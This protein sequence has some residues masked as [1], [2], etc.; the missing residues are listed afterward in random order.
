MRL[1]QEFSGYAQ[2]VKNAIGRI[3]QALEGLYELPLG[4]TAVGTG[5]NAP[6]GIRRRN[7]RGDR[8]HDRPVRSSK[9]RTTSKRRRRRMP[10][11][12]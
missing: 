11:C 2:Q 4:G 5:L 9:R 8:A 12:S 6:A 1:G 7:H 10:W 3:V